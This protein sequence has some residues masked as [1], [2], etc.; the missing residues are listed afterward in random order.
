MGP[1][2]PVRKIST[3]SHFKIADRR[4]TETIGWWDRRA[5]FGKSQR[6][7]ISKLPT[8][9]DC[10]DNRFPVSRTWMHL[11]LLL[12][13]NAASG[14]KMDRRIPPKRVNAKNLRR[15]ER[16]MRP[17]GGW[18]GRRSRSTGSKSRNPVTVTRPEC[19][20]LWVTTYRRINR[21]TQGVTICNPIQPSNTFHTWNQIL[22]KQLV[23][24]KTPI[25]IIWYWN[26]LL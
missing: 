7:L 14:S 4:P 2:S 8:G 10:W 17:P 13:T 3:P 20:T 5:P 23:W 21:V 18:R 16:G 24:D 22:V 12:E 26:N 1:Q 6:N 11:R 9:G 25:S 19:H 15:L